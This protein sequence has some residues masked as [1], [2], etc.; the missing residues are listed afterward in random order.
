MAEVGGRDWEGEEEDGNERKKEI[1]EK[2]PS[3]QRPVSLSKAPKKVV[4]VR[5]EGMM[6]TISV[7]VEEKA[8]GSEEKLNY[9]L[10]SSECQGAQMTTKRTENEVNDD[11]N[12]NHGCKIKNATETTRTATRS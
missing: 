3:C 1:D 10:V 11:D 4:K 5:E 12:N 9:Q 2:T 8:L 7:V 6:R